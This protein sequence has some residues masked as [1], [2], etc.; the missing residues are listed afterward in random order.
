MATASQMVCNLTTSLRV[1]LLEIV[2]DLCMPPTHDLLEIMSAKS[3]C[4]DQQV[5]TVFDMILLLQQAL[6]AWKWMTQTASCLGQNSMQ[7]SEGVSSGLTLPAASHRSDF[8]E[9][10][11]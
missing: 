2:P 10:A 7:C 4:H 9:Q 5:N 3:V 1:S 6:N 8:P 11:R